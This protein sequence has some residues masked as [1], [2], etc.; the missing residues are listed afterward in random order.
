MPAFI[1]VDIVGDRRRAFRAAIAKPPSRAVLRDL[2]LHL[3][4]ADFGEARG[5][6]H[7]RA[8]LARVHRCDASRD[9]RRPAA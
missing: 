3:L 5:K 1:T 4:F 9:A 6:D 8:D 2:V 7:R